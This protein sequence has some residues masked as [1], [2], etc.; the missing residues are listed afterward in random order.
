ML[1]GIQILRRRRRGFSPFLLSG[2]LFYEGGRCECA[3]DFD[4]FVLS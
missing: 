3:D 1:W 4:D 2:V